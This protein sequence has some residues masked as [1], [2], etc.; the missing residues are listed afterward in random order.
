MDKQSFEVKKFAQIHN[1]PLSEAE[2]ALG[3]VPEATDLKEAYSQYRLA[4]GCNDKPVR[5]KELKRWI[6]I[7]LE[8]TLNLEETDKVDRAEEYR[9]IHAQIPPTFREIR[10]AICLWDDETMSKIEKAKGSEILSVA[11][12]KAKATARPTSHAYFVADEAFH[13]AWE[14]DFARASMGTKDDIELLFSLITIAPDPAQR[15]QLEALLCEFCELEKDLKRLLPLLA[16][17]HKR[18]I[19]IRKLATLFEHKDQEPPQ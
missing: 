12:H 10:Q 2:R 1:I 5:E 19:V 13:M 7:E 4:N 9:R 14:R 11:L 6:S 8:K 15:L 17:N 3:I 16:D 18:G